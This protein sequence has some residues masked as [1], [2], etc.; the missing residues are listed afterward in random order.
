MLFIRLADSEKASCAKRAYANSAGFRLVDGVV[1][2]PEALPPSCSHPPGRSHAKSSTFRK[3]PARLTPT[4][5]IRRR[6]SDGR[7]PPLERVQCAQRLGPCRS[8]PHRFVAIR[9]RLQPR[10]ACH[11]ERP[12]RHEL[13]IGVIVGGV[14]VHDLAQGVVVEVLDGVVAEEA[15]ASDDAIPVPASFSASM[16]R[17]RSMS[18][19]GLRTIANENHELRAPSCSC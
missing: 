10:T 14:G 19:M 2:L 18:S 7:S 11:F 9:S 8:S 15:A 4:L 17:R 13:I 16:T 5:V 1:S 3:G 12:A 6:L